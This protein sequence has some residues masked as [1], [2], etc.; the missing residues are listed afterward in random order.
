MEGSPSRQEKLP[1]SIVLDAIS[2]CAE[3]GVTDLY[4]TGGEVILYR[5]LEEVL[6]AA[7]AH[8]GLRVTVCTNGML[9]NARH[10]ALFSDLRVKVNVSID[11]DESFHDYFRGQRGALHAAERG[12][13]LMVDAQ[14]P[15]SVVMT[16]S[17]GNLDCLSGTVE[18]A[19]NVGARGVFILPLLKLG[20][21]RDLADQCLTDTQMNLMLVQ[22]SDLANR[23]RSRGVTCSLN[24][25]ATRRFLMTHPCG[26]YVCNGAGCHRR[27]A[28]E[29][30]KLVVR[31][32]GTVLPELTN[33]SHD[34]ALGSVY[35]APLLTL[36][37]RF[38]DTDYARF[39]E[40]CRTTYAEVLPNWD[41]TIVPW[42]AIVAD[43]SYGWSNRNSHNMTIPDIGC[44]MCSAPSPT[45]ITNDAA[46]IGAEQPR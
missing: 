25:V 27:V 4:V 46:L 26:A 15:V 13:R 1:V 16:I 23:Y 21:G 24:G 2:Q 12:I 45:Q 22:L 38:M 41:S 36:V 8:E 39:D 9:V 44:E 18:W 42:D 37:E 10:A 33:L 3:L 5:G 28:R 20:R 14:V 31:E 35:E 29:I 30:K 43:R 7:A 40:L 32:D 6:R 17:R 11:G 19:A 34:F